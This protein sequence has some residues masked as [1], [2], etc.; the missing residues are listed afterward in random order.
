MTAPDECWYRLP[1]VWLGTAIFIASIAGC[2][3]VI[4]LAS[5]YSD[6]PLPVGGERVLKVPESRAAHEVPET[7][8]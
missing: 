6:E 5:H 8:R 7:L 2:I 1:I 4:V 3:A